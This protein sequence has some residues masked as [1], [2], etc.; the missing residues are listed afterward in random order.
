MRKNVENT[1]GVFFSSEVIKKGG[2]VSFAS[3]FFVDNQLFI[4]NNIAV[5]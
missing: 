4:K 1:E 3:P 5:S 2:A